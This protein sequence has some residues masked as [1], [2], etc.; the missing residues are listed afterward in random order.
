MSLKDFAESVT[1][2]NRNRKITIYH[3]MI[4]DQRSLINKWVSKLY[5]HDCESDR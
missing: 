4:C 3:Q 5:S 2:F 1:C